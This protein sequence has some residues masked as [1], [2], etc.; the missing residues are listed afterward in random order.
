M[1]KL[2]R[3]AAWVLCLCLLCGMPMSVSAAESTDKTDG[4]RLIGVQ[5]IVQNLGNR[6][7][8]DRML[9]LYF[10]QAVTWGEVATVRLVL[11]DSEGNVVKDSANKPIYWKT[12]GAATTNFGVNGYMVRLFSTEVTYQGQSV[13]SWSSIMDMLAN[14][15]ALKGKG[16]RLQVRV[17]EKNT[18]KS[19][20]GTVDS[21]VA[22]ANSSLWLKA[23]VSDSRIDQLGFAAGTREYACLD[24][25]VVDT[26][27]AAIVPSGVIR[28]ERAQMNNETE[29]TLTFSEAVAV[30]AARTEAVM[31]VVGADGT[32]V[33]ESAVTLTGN[34]SREVSGRLT[35]ATWAQMQACQQEAA[36]RTIRLQITESEP[37]AASAEFA[38]SYTVDCLRGAENGK[39]VQSTIYATDSSKKDRADYIR[40][41][42][43]EPQ[44]VLRLVGAQPITQTFS[45]TD[46]SDRMLLLYFNQ[47]VTWGEVATVRVV[48]VDSEGNVVTDSA[49]KAIYWKTGGNATTNFGVNG[50]M[51]RL[52]GT[53]VTYEGQTVLSWSAIADMLANDPALKG[54]EYRLQVRVYEKADGNAGVS[55]VGGNATVDSVRAVSDS[56][57]W[58]KADVSDNRIDQIGM[59]AGTREYACIDLGT[60]EAG[61]TAIV[62]SGVVTLD[63]VAMVDETALQL[64]FS[65]AVTVDPAR[66]DAKIE[67]VG[68]AGTIFMTA[69]VTLT[70]GN[71]KT[72][73]ATLTDTSWAQIFA[74]YS[75]N[76][77]RTIR[78][79]LTEKEIVEANA[80]KANNYTVDTVRGVE[81]GMPLR[82]NSY[83]SGANNAERM[84]YVTAVVE[85]PKAM[86]LERDETVDTLVVPAGMTLDLNGHILTVSSLN[87]YGDIVD[88][89]EG[90]GGIR[91]EGEESYFNLMPQNTAVALYDAQ[92]DCYRFFTPEFEAKA[93]EQTDAD[94]VK[95]AIRL[96]LPSAKAYAL[97]DDEDNRKDLFI[98]MELVNADG[99]VQTTIEYEFSKEIIEE[100]VARSSD[101]VK[102]YG[103][104]LT[105][106]GLEKVAA[107]GLELRAT[108]CVNA[109]GVQRSLAY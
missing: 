40:I 74:R 73:N 61:A 84:D 36:D 44:N 1:R 53:E 94:T 103:I 42:V 4:L 33:Q 7:W 99:T 86:I 80:E 41:A 8:N 100:Y 93:A 15:P 95:F 39:P 63:S 59:A 106:Q 105:V 48:L 68:T 81:N 67:V 90:E 46:W 37:N 91:M 3:L 6:D 38:N 76:T 45:S 50:Y 2:K 70:E 102:K 34:G 43:E 82:S 16:Y 108:A 97:L 92:A 109:G 47:A 27:A 65:D 32:V 89:T 60:V 52:F 101:M 83:T 19:G 17:Y 21:V 71:A 51:V 10:N 23:D 12:G 24:L 77:T 57:V 14:D 96:G 58:L 18:Y 5:P 62:P 107:A 22:A 31:Q 98:K 87:S 72:V 55:Y 54:K 64:N 85:G 20:N 88:G 66:T 78:L 69:A 75:E 9:L 26:G 35:E 49:N 25:G 104:S 11:V 56:S 29:V 28:L 79:K 13:L 30:D